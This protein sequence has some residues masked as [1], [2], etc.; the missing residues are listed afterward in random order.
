MGPLTDRATAQGLHEG[1]GASRQ[2]GLAGVR[3]PASRRCGYVRLQLAVAR[4][5]VFLQAPHPAAFSPAI[6]LLASAA[7]APAHR[8]T[9]TSAG[10]CGIAQPPPP[11]SEA[12]KPDPEERPGENGQTSLGVLQAGGGE[13]C[14]GGGGRVSW[15]EQRPPVFREENKAIMCDQ[16]LCIKEDRF[17]LLMCCFHRS[18][19]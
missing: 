3:L 15:E 13:G 8:P 9:P 19:A 7:A 4:V 11:P 14:E 6:Q 10:S 18:R 12:P 2:L 1:L 16:P 17:V 5:F